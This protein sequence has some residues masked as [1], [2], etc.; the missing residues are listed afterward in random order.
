MAKTEWLLLFLFIITIIIIII[1]LSF[2]NTKRNW[3]FQKNRPQFSKN[4]DE[5]DEASY[6]SVGMRSFWYRY[7]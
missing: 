7:L 2:N 1:I 6:R 5:T 4:T 3:E